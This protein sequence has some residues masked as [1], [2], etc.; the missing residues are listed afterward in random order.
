MT[1]VTT[2]QTGIHMRNPLTNTDTKT[3]KSVPPAADLIR[4]MRFRSPLI[5]SVTGD[6]TV[7]PAFFRT[8][9]AEYCD[10]IPNQENLNRT[11]P[12]GDTYDKETKDHETVNKIGIKHCAP[13]VVR[14]TSAVHGR[15]IVRRVPFLTLPPRYPRHSTA[16]LACPPLPPSSLG[17]TTGC[18]GNAA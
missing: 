2:V 10:T 8:S 3:S 9:P 1:H 5:Q 4:A 15:F 12:A 14:P 18:Y 17:Y 6:S 16:C 7:V 13:K 11:P